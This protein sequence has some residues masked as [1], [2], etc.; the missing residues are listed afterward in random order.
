MDFTNLDPLTMREHEG[1][2]IFPSHDEVGLEWMVASY[3]HA[4]RGSRGHEFGRFCW[5]HPRQVIAKQFC[6]LWLQFTGSGNNYCLKVHHRG[7]IIDRHLLQ[8]HRLPRLP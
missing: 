4:T 7:Q 6:K 8:T 3:G 2:L 5:E 1:T